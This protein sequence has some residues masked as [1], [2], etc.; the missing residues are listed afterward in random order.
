MT[1]DPKF[2]HFLVFFN[3]DRDYFE[4][5]EVMEELW[6]EEGRSPFWQG[7]LQAAVGLHHWRNDNYSGAVKLFRGAQEK[8]APYGDSE[9][10][11]DLAKLK[12]DVAAS[13]K[14]LTEGAPEGTVLQPPFEPFEIVITD[15]ELAREA[16]LLAA[17]P[18]EERL[19]GSES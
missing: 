6:L 11:L 9:A 10:G 12:A 3:V 8:L 15:A 13:L 18:Y 2:V 1:A 14:R 5:H 17:V 16:E 4:C 19:S 7:L